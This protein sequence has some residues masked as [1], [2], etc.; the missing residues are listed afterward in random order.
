ME[1]SRIGVWDYSDVFK[2]WIE[3]FMHGYRMESTPTLLGSNTICLDDIVVNKME[4]ANRN[5]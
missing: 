3:F 5:K 2:Y 4:I 1:E